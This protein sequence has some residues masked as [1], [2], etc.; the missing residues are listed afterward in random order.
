MNILI[1]DD[2]MV[3][4]KMVA[5]A[6][7]A[8]DADTFEAG[9]GEEALQILKETNGKIDL[10]FLDWNMPKM[11][12]L[13][14]LIHI[15]K[16]KDYKDIPVVMTTTVN[17]RENIIKAIQAGASQYLVKPF[18]QED[19]IKKI[20]ERIDVSASLRYLF[21]ITTKELIAEITGLEVE[22][23]ESAGLSE[24]DGCEFY[25]QMLVSGQHRIL[26]NYTMTREA[27]ESF[28]SFKSGKKS[29]KFEDKVLLSEYNKFMRQVAKSCLSHT[30][31]YGILSVYIRFCY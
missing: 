6:A 11:S 24:D 7:K 22:E 28:I 13:D 2:I 4:R 31:G 12:G 3:I 1:V 21:L 26:I 27:I 29:I 10:I 8:L 9:D 14:F 5:R 17:E 19:I 18:T 25:G 23:N 16:H 20:L 30:Q 15:K